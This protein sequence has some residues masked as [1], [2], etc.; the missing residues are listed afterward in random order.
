MK[1][2]HDFLRRL[3]WWIKHALWRLRI[4]E[5]RPDCLRGLISW[6]PVDEAPTHE[7]IRYDR[8]LS[9]QEVKQVTKYLEGKLAERIR[10]NWRSFLFNI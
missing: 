9:D 3:P 1:E 7:N 4:I 8:W 5:F 2:H 6:W 10:L